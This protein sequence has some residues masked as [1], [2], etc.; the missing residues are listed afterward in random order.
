MYTKEVKPGLSDNVCK[1]KKGK[2][3]FLPAPAALVPLLNIYKT[4]ETTKIKTVFSFN[5]DIRL[6]V[7]K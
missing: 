7:T 6:V 1:K 5:L 2:Y 3:D 4:K